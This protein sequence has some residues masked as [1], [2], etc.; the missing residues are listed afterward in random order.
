MKKS[1]LAACIIL[2]LA[3]LSFAQPV[4]ETKSRGGLDLI[5][6]LIGAVTGLII[7]YFIGS[8]IAKK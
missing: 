6:V 5:S 2:L 8:K 1:L 7:G 4:I 3:N